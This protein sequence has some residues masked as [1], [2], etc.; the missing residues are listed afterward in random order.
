MNRRFSGSDMERP[1]LGSGSE[2]VTFF[3]SSLEELELELEGEEEDEEEGEVDVDVDVDEVVVK[4]AVGA[5]C[6]HLRKWMRYPACC[7]MS[8]A[9]I[10]DLS[11]WR[12]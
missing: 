7:V 9:S 2:V 5:C 1:E 11:K 10:S 6:R 12:I 4:E 8:V 3:F